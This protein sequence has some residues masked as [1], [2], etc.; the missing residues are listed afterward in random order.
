MSLLV[1]RHTSRQFTVLIMLYVRALLETD[2]VA[3]SHLQKLLVAKKKGNSRQLRIVGQ[4]EKLKVWEIAGH[5]KDFKNGSNDCAGWRS[6]FCRMV[7]T[8]DWLM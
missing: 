4:K 8:T 5:T 6:G 7:I 2:L 3:H 1:N